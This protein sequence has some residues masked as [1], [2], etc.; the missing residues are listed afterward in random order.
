MK[1]IDA[2]K[3]SDSVNYNNHTSVMAQIYN[4]IEIKAERGETNLQFHVDKTKMDVDSTVSALKSNGYN[5]RYD[6][7][8]NEEWNYISISW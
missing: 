1:A 5:A 2:R 6:Q 8:D 4:E 7:R 3:I